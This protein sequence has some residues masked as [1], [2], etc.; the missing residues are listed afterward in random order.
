MSAAD[1]RRPRVVILAL[2]IRIE[3]GINPEARRRA[4]R[5]HDELQRWASSLPAVGRQEIKA[6][7]GD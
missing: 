3:I 4:V 2:E 6:Q 1:S 7:R 5:A